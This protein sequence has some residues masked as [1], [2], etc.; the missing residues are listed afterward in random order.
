[1]PLVEF[2]VPAEARDRATRALLV[3]LRRQYVPSMFIRRRKT[4]LNI[5]RYICVSATKF[6]TAS[7]PFVSASPTAF[8][9]SK[10][11]HKQ[12]NTDDRRQCPQYFP[13]CPLSLHHSGS[14]V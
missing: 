8:W 5:L 6:T 4:H 7:A 13:D 2:S 10:N 3:A 12:V 14:R 1:M 9:F 11:H